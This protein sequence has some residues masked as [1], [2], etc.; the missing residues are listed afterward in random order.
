MSNDPK[1]SIITAVYNARETI[2]DTLD[3]I[4]GQTWPNIELI[5]INGASDDGT[6][7]LLE[8]R[9]EHFD[10]YINEPDSGIYDA[11]NKGI[12]R[13]SGDVVGFLHADDI[14]G[15]KQSLAHIAAVFGNPSIDAIYGDL[16][17][18]SRN[19]DRI[20]RCWRAGEYSLNRLKKGWMPPHPTFYV[21]RSVYDRLGMFDTSYRIAAD[22]DC[23]LRF[24]FQGKLRCHYLPEVLVKMRLGGESNRSIQN[25]I[26]KSTEDY[27][28]LKHNR[29][30]GL[31]ALLWK[32]ISKIPQFFLR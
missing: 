18:V 21:R 22:Y 3:S 9:K 5:I 1:I 12:S 27:R 17:Y 23:M 32:N 8:A 29:V 25:M 13:A 24:I 6:T 7:E 26:C 10:V 2:G 11:L 31:T 19:K 16:L 14:F 30:G 15:S 4:L 20:I 28:A